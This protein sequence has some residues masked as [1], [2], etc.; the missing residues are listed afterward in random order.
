[1][2]FRRFISSRVLRRARSNRTSPLRLEKEVYQEHL[3]DYEAV[4]GTHIDKEHIHNHIAFNS[5]S[6]R[7]GKSITAQRNHTIG[8]YVRY[9]MI[10]LQELWAFNHF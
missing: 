8:R 2:A 6:F 3:P 7:T 4:L 1:M 10:F 9:P 5:V